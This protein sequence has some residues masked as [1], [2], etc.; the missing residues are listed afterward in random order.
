MLWLCCVAFSR[1]HI[2]SHILVGRLVGCDGEKKELT[3]VRIC[4]NRQKAKN[5]A[6][7]IVSL[8]LVPTTDLE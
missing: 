4:M 6:N 3:S 2:T 8:R 7:N 1:C 5:I